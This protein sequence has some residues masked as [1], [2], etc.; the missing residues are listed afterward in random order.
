[1]REWDDPS[2]RASPEGGWVGNDYI[3]SAKSG[4]R[5]LDYHLMRGPGSDSAAADAYSLVGVTHFSER[6]ESHK[7]LCHG[8]SMCAVMDDVV[9]TLFRLAVISVSK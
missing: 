2:W 8:G 6:A 1:V 7:G 9:G 3:H 5:V 4:V